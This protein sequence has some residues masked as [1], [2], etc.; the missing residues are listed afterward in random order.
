MIKIAIVSTFN[1]H[2]ECLGFLLEYLKEYKI[3][4]FIVEDNYKYLDYFQTL[5]NFNFKHIHEF[6]E[7]RY[8][9]I[10][11]LS[12]NDPY[13]IKKRH[14]SI[15]HYK[16]FEKFNNCKFIT[17]SPFVIPIKNSFSALRPF[18]VFRDFIFFTLFRL[19]MIRISLNYNSKV[20]EKFWQRTWPNHHYPVILFN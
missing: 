2:L 5:F 6:N 7:D 12:S 20:N 19:N 16:G 11:K 3:D 18:F 8:D 13:I 15:L 9:K 1:Y 17:L 10:I 14:I 4:I